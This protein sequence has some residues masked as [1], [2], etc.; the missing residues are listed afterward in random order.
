MSR[1]Q[2]ASF[3]ILKKY[4]FF[5]DG[6]KKALTELGKLPTVSG[7]STFKHWKEQVFGDPSI[8]IEVY[9]VFIPGQN[10]KVSTIK[11][12]WGGEHIN[13]VFSQYSR[14]KAKKS[15]EAIEEAEQEIV[16]R[17]ATFPKETLLSL[18]EEVNHGDGLQPPVDEFFQRYINSTEENIETKDILR[19]LIGTY[20]S[21]VKKY[22]EIS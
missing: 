13:A 7:E 20:N 18:L 10:T 12:D 17:L 19:D 2:S 16:E 8:E 11:R 4:G 22:R 9:S 21:V 14:L 5:V 6:P 1:E 15:N 3:R